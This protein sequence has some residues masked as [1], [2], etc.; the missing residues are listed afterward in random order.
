VKRLLS[1]AAIVVAVSALAPATTA[2]VAPRVDAADYL[3][4]QSGDLHTALVDS[5]NGVDLGTMH[6]D[7]TVTDVAAIVDLD[8][9]LKIT[10]PY[11]GDLIIELKHVDTGTT[12]T[13]IDRPG[14]PDTEFGCVD[15]GIALILD[16]EGSNGSVEDA[17]P[18][19]FVV[20]WRVTPN[21][22]LSLFDGESTEGTWRLIISDAVVTGTGYLEDWNLRF[23]YTTCDGQIV[24]IIG[25]S[26][27]DSINGTGG[28]DVIAGL[29][30]KDTIYGKG[31]DDVI[32]AGSGKDKVFAGSGN[33]TVF[34]EGGADTLS[35][36]NGNDD[37]NGNGG[38]DTI[39]YSKAGGAVT[40]DLS[41]GTATG[42]A[43]T[44]TLIK[45]E[46]IVG[47]PFGDSLTGDSAKNVIQ[48]GA[49]N[50]VMNG[51]GGDDTLKGGSGTDTANGGAGTDTCDAESTSACEL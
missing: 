42:G 38:K 30:G 7:I 23:G 15:A 10:H 22:A 19:Y 43:G 34:G 25:T 29:A 50:D 9:E 14:V 47:S 24:T 6:S 41:A 40:V 3:V 26:G 8:V 48:G 51:K 44:D 31:G 21:D 27:N 37:I 17:C 45:I 39:V 36:D 2:Q 46:K 1:V 13:L 35:G 33:D 12:I 28:P 4:W 11:P 20:D 5:P 18:L 49:G 32:C 16:D